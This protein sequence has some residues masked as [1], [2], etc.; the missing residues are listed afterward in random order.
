MIDNWSITPKKL[1]KFALKIDFSKMTEGTYKIF[2][3]K[4]ILIK[5]IDGLAVYREEGRSVDLSL[6]HF[7]IGS[8]DERYPDVFVLFVTTYCR[9]TKRLF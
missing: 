4:Q 8:N 5:G 2:D 3:K 9:G 7:E 6:T 1:P